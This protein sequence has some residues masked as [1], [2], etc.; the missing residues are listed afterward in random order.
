MD[1]ILEND[2]NCKKYSIIKIKNFVSAH[3]DH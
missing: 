2:C 1:K 3:L